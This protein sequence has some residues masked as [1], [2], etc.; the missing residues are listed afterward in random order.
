ME[1]LSAVVGTCVG[2]E[3]GESVIAP[4][5][6]VKENKGERGKRLGIS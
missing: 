5:A 2:L 1:K 6:I 3:G 4:G